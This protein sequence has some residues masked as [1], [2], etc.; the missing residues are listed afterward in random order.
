MARRKSHPLRILR[1]VLASIMLL[2]LTWLFLDTTGLSTK[3]LSWMTDLQFVPAWLNAI[4]TLSLGALVVV[5]LTIALT[6]I[7]GRLYCSVVC[8]LGILQDLFIW[9]GGRR[10]WRR[11][12]KPLARTRWNYRPNHPWVRATA[13]VVFL[14]LLFL[15]HPIASLFEPYSLFGRIVRMW[16]LP[17]VMTII[18]ALFFGFIAVWA[19]RDGRMWCNTV[20]PVGALL[21][22]M[23]KYSIRQLHIDLDKCEGC[24]TCGTKCKAQCID[25][26]NHKVD[27]SRCVDCFDCMNICPG[28]AFSFQKPWKEKA[29]KRVDVGNTVIDMGV[30]NSRRQFMAMTG[31]L[32]V[33][34]AASAQHK[35]T[36][37]GLAIIE[38]K[39]VPPRQVPLKPAGSVSLRDFTIICTSC[40]LCVTAC[41][42]K[43]LR[44][45]T[46]LETLL[47]PELH[48]ENGYCL[49]GCTR[50]GDIC[51]TGAI[52]PITKEQK[53]TIQIGHA[54]WIA[55]NCLVLSEGEVCGNC[56]R[57]CPTGAIQMVPN[58]QGQAVPA[59]DTEKC[60]GCGHCEYVCPSRPF[61]AIYVEGNL[62]HRT[63]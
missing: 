60:I 26:V 17:L 34:A 16:D 55:E 39:Q 32:A 47:Q 33:A 48:Y 12:V 5:I 19:L 24:G 53:T 1:I 27:A 61:S 14:L 22:L 2:G 37:G 11:H 25:M 49:P 62:Q 43:V 38:D 7:Y 52:T 4:G 46:K 3:Y 54:V 13:A 15:W 63:I 8:P 9:L 35:T 57:H 56:A 51:P 21:G 31:A 41:P 23:S 59:V 36:D 50:C 6:F 10:W 30:D 40:Q 29:S 28:H 58:A 42:E 18:T 20:C 45:S 44:P